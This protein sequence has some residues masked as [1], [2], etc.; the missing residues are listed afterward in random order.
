[1]W[2]KE[3]NVMA[4]VGGVYTFGMA[5][6]RQEWTTPK[7]PKQGLDRFLPLLGVGF[8]FR[9]TIQMLAANPSGADSLALVAKNTT[10]TGTLDVWRFFPGTRFSFCRKCSDMCLRQ[11]HAG[12]IAAIVIFQ[13]HRAVH[14]CS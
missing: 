12:G 3:L 10:N 4:W 11:L 9:P 8:A 5:Q 6:R 2:E 1:M 14:S 13:I 7:S